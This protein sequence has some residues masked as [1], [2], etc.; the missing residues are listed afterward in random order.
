M[1]RGA[2]IHRCDF[3]V[4]TPRDPNWSGS[5]PVTDD[6]RKAYARDFIAACRKKGLDAVAI[7]DHHDMLFVPYIRQAALEETRE[8]GSALEPHERITVFPGMEL[9]LGVP[10]QAL[11]ILDADLPDDQLGVVLEAL[12]ITPIPA[13]EPQQPPASV[14]SHTNLLSDVHRELDKREWLRGRYI[15]FPHVTDKGH[16]TLMRSHMGPKYAEMPCVGG[17]VDGDFESKTGEGNRK[18][19]AGLDANYGNKRIAVFQ[20]SDSRGESF[21]KLG[22]HSTWV[23]WAEPTAEALRQACLAQESRISLESPPLPTTALTK[24]RVSNSKFM[25]PIDLEFNA[26]YN[27]IIGGRGTGK[28]TCLEYIRWALC[29]QPIQPVGD[30]ELPDHAQRRDALIADTLSSMDATVDVEFLVNDVSHTVRRSSTTGELVLKVGTEDFAPATE[31]DIRALLPMNAYS[32]KQLS[33]VGVRKEELTRFLTAPL[34]EALELTRQKLDKLAG[35]IR[36]NYAA[37]QQ[38]RSVERAVARD[39]LQIQSLTQQADTLRASLGAVTEEDQT[40]LSQKPLHDEADEALSEWDRSVSSAKNA[41]SEFQSEITRLQAGLDASLEHLPNADQLAAVRSELTS[42]L[43]DLKAQADAAVARTGQL[44]APESQYN[45]ALAA[46]ENKRTEFSTAYDSAKERSSAHESRLKQ[47]TELEG[48]QRAIRETLGE[49]RAELA[50]LGDPAAEHT[51]LREQWRTLHIERHQ[52]LQAQCEALKSASNGL[53]AAELTRAAGLVD[54][55]ERFRGAIARSNVRGNKVESLLGAIVETDEPFALWESVLE[56]LES[57]AQFEAGEESTAPLPDCPQLKS[58][59]FA[60]TD[61]QRIGT[62]LTPDGWLDLA[63]APIE[64]QPRFR[65]QVRED[66]FIDFERASAGQQATALLRVLLNQGGPPLLIDQPEDDLD[67]QVVVEVVERLWSAKV[68]RQLIFTS[69]NANL[70]VNGD[71]ELV[72]CCDYREATDHSGGRI[73]LRGAIDVGDVREEITTVME[74][75][76]RAFKLRKEKYGF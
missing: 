67:S 40:T 61:L 32:Q 47:L 41:A 43:E 74:G 60:I 50:Q 5:V 46:L 14:L 4:H 58:H 26:Q 8:D 51:Q 64:D 66:E 42:L 55:T 30:E 29:D 69:H 62:R 59:G 56:E 73:K 11:L 54:L 17:Y 6:E 31:V 72:V 38:R 25:G 44:R 18:I 65:Y 9:T 37:L 27:A 7:T 15:L 35:D 53:I 52:L 16:Q 71:A 45:T 57:L 49:Q 34:Q 48:R 68:S 20:T 21:E 3:Q 33:S 76:E 24:L 70:V 39:D 23:K 2:H 12:A 10:C 13:E 22:R 36:Q 1:D 19:F 63:L 28:S 75:G